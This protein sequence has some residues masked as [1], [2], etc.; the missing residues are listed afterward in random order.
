MIFP[1]AC[2]VLLASCAPHPLPG[3]A[4]GDAVQ[5][6]AVADDPLTGVWSGKATGKSPLIPAEGVPLELVLR[7]TDERAARVR[8]DVEGREGQEVD[9]SFDPE[10]GTLAFRATFIGVV[11]SA[12]L[13]VEG[14][15]L[16][17]TIAGLGISAEVSAK[18]TSRELPRKSTSAPAT[19]DLARLGP[20]DWR[21]DLEE[22][23]ARLPERHVNAFHT[24]SKEDWQAAVRELE[25]RLPA[26]DALDSA[27]ALA[28]LVARVGDAHT[29]LAW[30]HLPGFA[31]V[32][33][34]LRVFADGLF[35]TEVDERWGQALATR[36]VRVGNATAAEA[37]AAVAT[38]FAAENESWRRA[39]A[40]DLLTIPRLLV[41]LGLSSS[42]EEL[43][44]V[45]ELEPG[46]EESIT[47]ALSGSGT[48]LR[49]PDPELD[50]IPLWQRRT[51]ENYWFEAL[52]GNTLYFAYNRCAESNTRPFVPFVEELF[53][54]FEALDAGR[55]IVDLRHN[56]G[57][58]SVI[59]GPFLDRLA[60]LPELREP[61]RLVALIGP[62]TYSSGMLNAFQLRQAGALLVGEPTGGKPN[63]YGELV[64]F[65]LPRSGL[66]VFHSTKYFRMLETD[67]PA[68]EPDVLVEL[69]SQDH[70]FG[71][72]PVLEHVLSGR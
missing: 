21:A 43:P 48:W 9:A 25:A 38:T 5:A 14:E 72:D 3:A 6:I 46:A 34:R 52:A 64:S 41:A 44:L 39:K 27:V 53:A 62:V 28:R 61:G 30:R 69:G 51:G 67:P 63:S 31:S 35:V 65:D 26:L 1:Y 19:V 58:N 11:L 42:A 49:A 59:L 12:E 33:V 29:E 10:A 71:R 16:A 13:R 55:L 60:A 15:E 2:S 54:K 56:S 66:T 40:P 45:V 23:S 22:L 8:L 37:L 32:P 50:S 36:V 4:R 7:R 17:G 68:V 24:I 57:G 18:R 70:F 47:I 20:E